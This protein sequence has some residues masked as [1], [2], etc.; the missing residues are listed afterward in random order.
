MWGQG[1]GIINCQQNA[2]NQ[3]RKIVENGTNRP[4]FER[5]SK[6]Y[7]YINTLVYI[8]NSLSIQVQGFLPALYPGLFLQPRKGI[9]GGN[10]SFKFTIFLRLFS[11]S[12]L[13]SYHDYRG[14]H[15]RGRS[16]SLR[17]P[18]HRRLVLGRRWCRCNMYTHTHMFFTYMN[19]LYVY[20]SFMFE[21]VIQRFYLNSLIWHEKV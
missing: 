15:L 11:I 1:E 19:T 18:F 3:K 4:Y 8:S 2:Y 13:T 21:I 14:P 6:V 16:R 7:N 12:C 10:T 9:R 20:I 17:R 5:G